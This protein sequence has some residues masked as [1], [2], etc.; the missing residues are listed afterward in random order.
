MAG[1]SDNQGAEVRPRLSRTFRVEL[2]SG[3]KLIYIA[4]GHITYEEA[5]RRL[6]EKF[7][8]SGKFIK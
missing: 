7:R 4:D 6:R 1:V 8:Q 5:G 2:A 3:H